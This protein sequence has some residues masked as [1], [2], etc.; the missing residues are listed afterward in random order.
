MVE[1][2][3]L[4]FELRPE[5]L[6]TEGLVVGLGKQAVALSARHEVLV[7]TD[8]C[9][10]PQVPLVAKEA[11]YR[12]GQEALHNAF[13]HAG[14]TKV[15]LQLR[16]S[17]SEVVLEVCDDGK[18]FDPRAPTRVILACTRWKSG[19]P[20][21]VARSR[22]TAES[23]AA[24][25][26]VLASHSSPSCSRAGRPRRCFHVLGLA[27]VHDRLR[28]AS[29]IVILDLPPLLGYAYTPIA[30]QAA[31]AIILVIRAGVTPVDIAQQAIARLGNQSPRG[32]VLNG[33]HSSLPSWAYH[34]F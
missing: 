17:K 15:E 21:L 30:A 26:S 10:E 4:L 25:S 9:E 33:V 14:P 6:E 11:L 19:R 1:M 13:K 5:S 18:G 28:L 12:I 29:G 16:S 7:E 34:L 2:R 3:T 31:E 24:R 20:A 32:V 22:W 27:Q 23:A 8:L